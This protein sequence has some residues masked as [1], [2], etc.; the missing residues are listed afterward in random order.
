MVSP[1]VGTCAKITETFLRFGK[2]AFSGFVSKYLHFYLS[3]RAADGKLF[4]ISGQLKPKPRY[5]LDVCTLGRVAKI[6]TGRLH[7]AL[8]RVYSNLKRSEW[9]VLTKDHTVLPATR[10]LITN[11]LQ[12]RRLMFVVVRKDDDRRR[13]TPATITI[14]WPH[15]LCV[16][17]PN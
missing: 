15:T 16:D 2:D 13:Q 5:P 12:R 6:K 3:L 9:H 4:Y 7:S 17:G 11:T 1:G 10:T 14:V 8:S